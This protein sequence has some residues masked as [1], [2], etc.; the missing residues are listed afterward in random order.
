MAMERRRFLQLSAAGVLVATTGTGCR[1]DDIDERT[2]AHP[3]V[4]ALLGPARVREIGVRYR[5][6]LPA[7]RAAP[8]LRAA[9]ANDEYGLRLPWRKRQSLAER[10]SSDFA[11]GRTVVV[12]GWLLSTTEARQCA[13]FS[14][15]PS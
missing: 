1:G 4:L 3:A 2:L 15:L 8:A 9:I 13:L 11:A 10:I 12:N 14:L 6:T 7:E 5:Q